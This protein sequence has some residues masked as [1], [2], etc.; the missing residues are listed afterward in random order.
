VSALSSSASCRCAFM[1]A[2]ISTC[3][4]PCTADP[5]LPSLCHLLHLRRCRRRLRVTVVVVVSSSLSLRL[6]QAATR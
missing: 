4:L 3:T 5:L 6:L 2:F 1:S